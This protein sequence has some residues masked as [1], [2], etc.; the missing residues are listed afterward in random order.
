MGGG[1]LSRLVIVSNRVATPHRRGAA[2]GG[3]AT[4]LLEAMNRQG[5]LWFGWNGRISE[6]PSPA[7][8]LQTEGAITFAVTPLTHRE[9]E[10]YYVG[11]ANR[12]LWPVFHAQLHLL[13]YDR[14]S[15]ETYLEVNDRWAR[16]LAPLI[17]PDDIVWI[18]DYHL[19]P[20]GASLRAHGVRA[21]LG[22][23][24]HTPFPGIDLLRALPGQTEILE[25]LLA[26]DLV[27][28]QTPF[29]CQSLSRAIA[30]FLPEAEREASCVRFRGHRVRVDSFPIGI[31]VDEV[32]R[33]ARAG[34]N[35]RHGRRLATSLAG[36][37]L[38]LGI[39]RLDYSKGLAQRFRSYARLLEQW[40]EFQR[41]VVLLQIAPLSRTEVP[42]YDEI[43]REL[44][45]IVGDIHA[46]YAEYD[47]MPLRYLTRGFPR[48]TIL[49]F[50]RQAE[51]G[52]ITPLRDGMNLV[53][54][55]F[56][57]AQPEESPGV[58]I[59]SSLAGAAQE[60]EEALI[61]NPYDSGEVARTLARALAMGL[62][63][64]HRRWEALMGRLRRRDLHHWTETFLKALAGTFLNPSPQEH[65]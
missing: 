9:F 16:M 41:Q 15:F 28:F 18:H 14:S 25:K 37:R 4:G 49:G 54:K 45:G 12:C 1:I 62:D 43:R 46:R 23:F 7:P 8:A 38:I 33:V 61:V 30:F 36:R 55:E 26:Y 32:A 21:P 51:I 39:D 56:V 42:E 5:G 6:N 22:F 50:L 31:D 27:G 58:L 13:H 47:W 48:S 2:Q 53:A 10:G 63:E 3:L 20:L 24:L 64:R 17:R 35:N 57:A 44:N 40:P 34:H 60:L 65:P 29:D 52:L 19:I 59:L 11:F